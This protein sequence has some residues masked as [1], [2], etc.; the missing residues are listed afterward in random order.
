MDARSSGANA[1]RT[2]LD[3][4]VSSAE[5]LCLFGNILA[6]P[7][8]RAYLALLRTLLENQDRGLVRRAAAE[9]FHALATAAASG[10]P[11]PGDA[12]Q[13]YLLWR[14]FSDDNPF[15]RAAQRWQFDEIPAGLRE[16]ARRDLVAIGRLYALN[17]A[18]LSGAVADTLAEMPS[19]TDF[20]GLGP[21][22][23]SDP[24]ATRFA[25]TADLAE[26]SGLLPELAARYRRHG[27]GPFAGHRAFRW[28]RRRDGGQIVPI[29]R[30]DPITFDDLFG[31]EEQRRVVR[32][33]T[34]SFLRGL[35]ANN[36]LLY[37]DRG[38]GK[39]STVKA[40]LNAYADQGLRL[41]EV[42]KSAL[43]DF[44]EIVNRLAERP[45]RFIIFVD[46][47][48]FDE[49]EGGYTELK[50]ILEGGVEV[51]PENVILYATSNRRHLV[52]ERFSDRVAPGD[53][54]HAQDTLQEKLSLADR[55]G[56]T[57]IF[58]TPD[59]EQYLRIVTGLARRRGL[60]VD[61]ERLRRQA[62]QWASWNNGRSGRTARQF[63]D[64][65]TATLAGTSLEPARAHD[66][67]NQPGND[68][69]PGSAMRR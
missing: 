31:Y 15:S 66:L 45:E 63:I 50:A 33:N 5:R 55:F 20:E 32:R 53:E 27:V 49:G 60:A 10:L 54:V 41:V 39:S 24:L 29:S 67:K 11:G 59:Q 35:P 56:V 62:L 3:A 21:E 48:S 4:A 30:P 1:H 64:D 42:A 68:G 8:G 37:G 58:G 61:E 40:L 19:W 43:G 18:R 69:R 2:R 36:L 65:L 22:R 6:D 44:P 38:T 12:W 34:E 13:R 25:S 7:P 51:R 28:E 47:L 52:L 16:A 57:V 14:V 23:P 9:L 46:D 26:W 17:G